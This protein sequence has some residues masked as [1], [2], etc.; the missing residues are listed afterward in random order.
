M[1]RST[2]A[3]AMVRGTSSSNPAGC[4]LEGCAMER[5]WSGE[6]LDIE[7]PVGSGHDQLQRRS[8]AEGD[9]L[10]S[11]A[12]WSAHE[13]GTPRS[14]T[15]ER[16][17]AGW[18][19]TQHRCPGRLVDGVSGAGG[20]EVAAVG[21]AGG[22]PSR[23]PC[24][25]WS[26]CAV[27][28]LLPGC[29]RPSVPTVPW[30][31]SALERFEAEQQAARSDVAQFAQYFD[32]T[33][34]CGDG[35]WVPGVGR[36]HGR[37]DLVPSL[38][39]AYG[40]AFEELVYEEVFIDDTGAVVQARVGPQWEGLEQR[41]YGPAGIVD[42]HMYE[43]PDSWGWGPI[44]DDD[45]FSRLTRE[46]QAAWTSNDADR[47]AA[48]YEP[49]AVLL[50]RVV[51]VELEGADG[52]RDHAA[53]AAGG[54]R[55]FG[56]RT[57]PAA[58]LFVA[59]R[60]PPFTLTLVFGGS[61][62]EPCPGRMA[63]VLELEEM[64]REQV[65]RIASERRFRNVEDVRRCVPDPRG[66]WWEQLEEVDLTQLRPVSDRIQLADRWIEVVWPS[67]DRIGLLAWALAR[68][69]AAGLPPPELARVTFETGTPR[70]AGI[71]GRVLS[72]G[73]GDA[74]LV[75]CLTD[76][77]I[78]LASDD[79][80]YSLH[81]RT[82]ILHELG[83]VWIE[84]HLRDTDRAAYLTS[85]GLTTWMGTEV[86]WDQRGGERA[87]EVMMWGLLD[88]DMPLSRLDTPAC[89]VLQQEFRALT[90]ADPPE[91]RCPP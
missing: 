14:S 46:Y 69:D 54:G 67:P 15:P 88:V 47:V 28:A 23:V 65:L 58:E 79:A 87:A 11:S 78:R 44:P 91:P 52:I 4:R 86:S 68:F 9:G 66:G 73:S 60:P 16:R 38:E 74:E 34:A 42:S 85:T 26:L 90:G 49:D 31:A 13:E 50:D 55:P 27:L 7:V 51:G 41:T 39:E 19:R 8:I 53:S 89:E 82:T 21:A 83:H 43:D 5:H 63:V 18:A 59:T 72:C 75:L 40:D 17:G 36:V 64:G 37:Q 57:E 33:F 62:D 32:P 12:V 48:L 1:S 6:L 3:L 84:S 30:A 56:A 20:R 22:N 2:V 77:Q 76:E 35:E 70:C 24:C 29:G 80:A 25:V 71:G 81:A 45:P 10:P 61:D